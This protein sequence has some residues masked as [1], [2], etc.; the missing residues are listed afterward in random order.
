[1]TLAF[2]CV[3]A[4]TITG[5][6]GWGIWLAVTIDRGLNQP[7]EGDDQPDKNDKDQ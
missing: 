4:L 6:I 3:M 1:M 7:D 2:T 5:L